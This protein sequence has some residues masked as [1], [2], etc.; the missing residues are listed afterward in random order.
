V[1]N[2][3]VRGK[4]VAFERPGSDATMFAT[5]TVATGGFRAQDAHPD[6]PMNPNTDFVTLTVDHSCCSFDGAAFGGT[7]VDG[8]GNQGGSPGA[9]FVDSAGG[10]YHQLSGSGTLDNGANDVLNGSFDFDGGARILGITDIGADEF[11]SAAATVLTG[12]AGG[13]GSSGA[14]LSGTVNPNGVSTN[15]LF[16]YGTTTAYGQQT[17]PV[18]VGSDT[19]DHSVNSAV[20]GLSPSTTY[21]YRIVGTNGGSLGPDRTLT[22]TAA[23]AGGGDPLAGP[24]TPG[25]P[26]PGGGSASPSNAFTFGRLVASAKR[27]TLTFSPTLPGPGL[28]VATATANVTG[29]AR[30]IRV[31]RLRRAVARAGRLKLVLKPS[32][33]ALKVL[34]RKGRL[35]ARLAVTY[36]PTGGTPR[37]TRRTVT[38]RLRRR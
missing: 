20:S 28:L 33:A 24:G 30:S 7:L 35:R 15:A 22:T 23:P 8:G 19:L 31:A 13:V 14:T 16:E 2:V 27:G 25:G 18:A 11:G 10:D 29:K 6:S 9:Q 12:A 26:G 5:N 4:V 21:H 34:K 3:T 1:R 38:F 17:A 37:T 32:R 36:T